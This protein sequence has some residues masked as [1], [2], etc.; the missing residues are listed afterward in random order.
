[1][2]SD[3]ERL[4]F[5]GRRQKCRSGDALAGHVCRCGGWLYL[6]DNFLN[7]DHHAHLLDHGPAAQAARDDAMRI[8]CPAIFAAAASTAVRLRPRRSAESSP[9]KRAPRFRISKC[10]M[11]PNVV[12][13]SMP[14]TET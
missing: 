4:A 6:E 8:R 2:A 11:A 14:L 7:L 3:G 9:R 1:M 12:R 10:K 5:G 13:A